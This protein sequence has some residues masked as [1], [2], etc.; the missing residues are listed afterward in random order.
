[1]KPLVDE[2]AE[3]VMLAVT[4]VSYKLSLHQCVI[5]VVMAVLSAARADHDLT[6]GRLNSN[7]CTGL[8]ESKS[9]MKSVISGVL[10]MTM[11]S[12]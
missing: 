7:G 1:M 5:T 4:P 2:C 10:S 6:Q 3:L 11:F 9:L 8:S 12:S